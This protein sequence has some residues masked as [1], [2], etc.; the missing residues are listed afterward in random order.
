M[1]LEL[2]LSPGY[3]FAK[4]CHV[5][6]VADSLSLVLNAKMGKEAGEVFIFSTSH[7]NENSGRHSVYRK[8][9]VCSSYYIYLIRCVRSLLYHRLFISCEVSIKWKFL[10]IKNI[11]KNWTSCDITKYQHNI[12][13]TNLHLNNDIIIVLVKT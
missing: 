1:L 5:V 2:I 7:L 13:I 3:K 9:T 8:S 6:V 11:R 10:E 4:Q 12:L